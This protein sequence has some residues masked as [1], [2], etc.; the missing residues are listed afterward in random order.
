MSRSLNDLD[1]AVQPKF[2]ELLARFTEAGIPV[3][4]IFTRRTQAEQDALIA[5]GL[6]WTNNSRHLIGRAIDVCPYE[7]FQLH[8]PDKLQWDGKDPVWAQLGKIGKS[9]GFVWG[10]DWTQKDLGH[11]EI[12]LPK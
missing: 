1:P 10:G 3:L 11:F 9:L 2:F 6:S 8:G 5:A 4:V 12:P 7:T